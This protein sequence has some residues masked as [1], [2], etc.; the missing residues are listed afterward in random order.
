M[1]IT[2]NIFRWQLFNDFFTLN[3]KNFEISDFKIFIKLVL[4]RM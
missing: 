4:A 2:L 1:K 3:N